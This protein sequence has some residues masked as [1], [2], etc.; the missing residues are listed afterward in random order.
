[1]KPDDP[2]QPQ[3]NLHTPPKV[4]TTRQA[5]DALRGYAYQLVASAL[6]WVDIDDHGCL[7]LEVAEDYAVIAGDAL[8]AFQI[9]DTKAS[10]TVTLNSESVRKAIAGFVDLTEQ[11]P[12][13]QI[14]LH[15]ITTCDIGMERAH[16][17]RP[18]GISGLTY[19][20]RA[21]R[22]S[23]IPPLRAQLESDRF[24]ES[25]RI[26]CRSRDDEE[27][28]EGIVRRIHWHCG[29]PPFGTLHQ[30]LESRLVVVA[31]NLFHVPATEARRL[32]DI[33]V[34]HVLDRIVNTPDRSL[35]RAD[36]YALIDESTRVSM[37]RTAVDRILS[38]AASVSFAD[39][40]H[41]HPSVST[42][43]PSW[44]IDNSPARA[45]KGMIP[46]PTIDSAV[47]DALNR[48]G[49][50]LL[51]GA[52]GLG[53]S[54]A[55]ASVVRQGA[56]A[57]A[58]LGD[59]NAQLTRQRV[60]LLFA[61]IT[62]LQS[63]VLILED[64]NK[65]HNKQVVAAVERLLDAARTTYRAVIITC[66]RTPSKTTLSEM[67]VDPRSVVEC[68][69]FSEEETSELV[70]CNGG[71]PK[72]WGTIAHI[73]AAG[74]HP[75]LTHAF[76]TGMSDRG[77][78]IHEIPNLLRHSFSSADIDAARDEARHR[79][80]ESI[81]DQARILLY[82]LSLT[83][84]HFNRST[85]LTVGGLS[86]PI[87]QAGECIDQLIGPWIEQ[88]GTALYRVSP[89]AADFGRKM[90]APD[91]Q[92]V[93]HNAIAVELLKSSTVSTSDVN[94]VVTH[95]L[96]GKATTSLSVVAQ[97]VLSADF[98]TLDELAENLVVFRFFGTDAPI[99]HSH[100][101][102]SALLR[103]VQF[104]VI[105][106]AGDPDRQAATVCASLFDEIRILEDVEQ[107]QRVQ[108]I[109]T[110]SLLLTRGTANHLDNWVQLLSQAKA[111]IEADSSL[112]ETA[113]EIAD[114]GQPARSTFCGILFSVGIANLSSVERL[115]YVVNELDKLDAAD[116]A[117]WLTPIDKEFSDYYTII[118]QPWIIEDRHGSLDASD[119]AERYGRMAITT[120]DWET[121]PFAV[122]CSVAQAV[123]LYELQN[124]NQRAL[125]VLE[126]ATATWGHNPIL[127]G[128]LANFYHYCGEHAKA[129]EIYQRIAD[130]HSLTSSIEQ[131]YRLRRSAISA[132]KEGRW[133]QA[134]Q[135]FLEAR[136]A[137]KLARSDDMRPIAIGLG[138]D[139]AVAASEMGDNAQALTL[140]AR[141]LEA[142]AT[143]ADAESL[144]AAYCHRVVRAAVLWIRAKVNRDDIVVDGQHI[145]MAPGVC[146]EPEPPAQVHEFALVDIDISWYYLTEAEIAA[147][148][149]LDVVTSLGDRLAKGEIPRME[150]GLSAAVMESAIDRLDAAGFSAHFMSYVDSMVY[151]S[152]SGGESEA[153]FD[154]RNPN[155]GRIPRIDRDAPFDSRTE[156]LAIEAILAF[157]IRAALANRPHAMRELEDAMG[158]RINGPFPGKKALDNWDDGSKMPTPRD[159]I[160]V[161]MIRL[162]GSTYLRPDRF[163]MA[164]MA[165]LTWIRGS[166][167]R[168]L[169]MARL[170][171]WQRDGWRRIVASESFRF[172]RPWQTLPLVEE[173][174]SIS[175]DDETFVAS[176]LL[177]GSVSIGIPVGPSDLDMLKAIR[178]GAEG[179]ESPSDR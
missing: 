102:T 83:I 157:G 91:D 81:P 16:E 121:L 135:W 2:L 74:G 4:D 139:A 53:K 119:A 56:F 38:Q 105:V 45:R 10:G 110:I 130:D 71:D 145:N 147:G 142:L 61:R 67:N 120:R 95:A 161:T 116:R 65:L 90:L 111:L 168:P 22:R 14:Y 163:W 49:V 23:Q 167:L 99:Y 44:L 12:D 134:M 100:H 113:L 39:D 118:N 171:G 170:A 41:P 106:T 159:Q 123:M 149:D 104:K 175:Q 96:L 54:V 18:A 50:A 138:A 20:R 98:P 151:F 93:I 6:A 136:Q 79:L 5:V 117:L 13:K 59:L 173:S 143:I 75:Q 15:L 40:T 80:A 73:A 33:L 32:A 155:R 24:P 68:P 122:H 92:V 82:R 11:N 1:M 156:Q 87:Q 144:R 178:R 51:V 153:S 137:A 35:T 19:W 72:I 150:A 64:L 34:S 127:S 63:S 115:E 88:F 126:N 86:P 132:A 128:A 46:R 29:S 165:L 162:L 3:G 78:P 28:R 36:L 60:D 174:L 125:S 47:S 52:S 17:H 77:W 164:G 43:E 160:A 30:L 101:L 58:H 166:N 152:R 141:A 31:R 148:A 140:L 26:F 7:H 57:S 48:F 114:D 176:V 76:V 107:R 85:A 25:V 124:D 55:S 94:V 69:C 179:A 154:P 172:L 108:Q 27:L 89:L 66:Y 21:A 42:A 169:L 146:S 158:S 97:L 84:G 177:S 9:K 70:R 112:K 131:A 103:L 8:R 109:A 37:P 129:L 62:A 133:R